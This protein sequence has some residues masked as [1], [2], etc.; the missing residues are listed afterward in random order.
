MTAVLPVADRPLRQGGGVGGGGGRKGGWLGILKGGAAWLVRREKSGGGKGRGSW[1]KVEGEE[2]RLQSEV[3][4][5]RQ[6]CS[7]S[8]GD[9]KEGKGEER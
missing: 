6:A 3:Y 2:K 1:G 5:K 8:I 4:R 7:E 9:S